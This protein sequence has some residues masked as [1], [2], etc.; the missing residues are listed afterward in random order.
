[1]ATVLPDEVSQT[2]IDNISR[3]GKNFKMRIFMHQDSVQFD[4]A[5]AGYTSGT[6]IY[7]FGRRVWVTNIDPL[8]FSARNGLKVEYEDENGNF[9]TALSTIFTVATVTPSVSLKVSIYTKKIRVTGF[10]EAD[11]TDDLFPISCKV[12]TEKKWDVTRNIN[13][14]VDINT[15]ASPIDANIVLPFISIGLLNEDGRWNKN[16]TDHFVKAYEDLVAGEIL[17]TSTTKGLT[18]LVKRGTRVSC[19]VMFLG[20]SF[21]EDDWILIGVFFARKWKTTSVSGEAAWNAKTPIKSPVLEGDSPEDII[22]RWISRDDEGTII[23]FN[24]SG[25]EEVITVDEEVIGEI[26]FEPVDALI[27]HN[28]K[29]VYASCVDNLYLFTAER[30]TQPINVGK[31]FG[32]QIYRS[33]HD[34]S[35]RE[36]IGFVEAICA[37]FQSNPTISDGQ[38]NFTFQQ[39]VDSGAAGPATAP[40]GF[41]SNDGTTSKYVRDIHLVADDEYLWITYLGMAQAHFQW[42]GSNTEDVYYW[43]QESAIFRLSKDGSGWGNYFGAQRF[44]APVAVPQSVRTVQLEWRF[45]PYR[46]FSDGYLQVNKDFLDDSSPFTP[47]IW[48][49]ITLFDDNGT[50]K[51]LVIRQRQ[52]ETTNVNQHYWKQPKEITLATLG[53]KI[54]DVAASFHIHAIM[55]RADISYPIMFRDVSGAVF[56]A[57]SIDKDGSGDFFINT[58]GQATVASRFKSMSYIGGSI[59]RSSDGYL[60]ATEHVDADGVVE[61]YQSLFQLDGYNIIHYEHATRNNFLTYRAPILAIGG[62]DLAKDIIEYNREFVSGDTFAT[63]AFILDLKTGEITLRQFYT[64]SEGETLNISYDFI[65][66]FL[67]FISEAKSRL[68]TDALGGISQALLDFY[69][70]NDIGQI[71]HLKFLQKQELP[72]RHTISEYSKE[73]DDDGEGFTVFGVGT[74]VVD[75]LNAIEFTPDF[76]GVVDEIILPLRLE[77]IG[78]DLMNPWVA[79]DIDIFITEAFSGYASTD[80]ETPNSI[81]NQANTLSLLTGGKLF[82]DKETVD[83]GGTDFSPYVW[84]SW[85]VSA[86]NR[87]V[88]AGST[89][90]IIFRVSNSGDNF[91]YHTLAKKV[92]CLKGQAVRD[93]IQPAEDV[94]T[95]T[96]SWT[97]TDF[98]NFGQ[99]PLVIV[100]VKTTKRELKSVDI[101]D[102]LN[103]IISSGF[104]SILGGSDSTI[105]VKD[106]ELVNEFV[107]TTDYNITYVG[108]KF[109]I[110]FLTFDVD[111]IIVVQWFDSL[112][113]PI[114][115]TDQKAQ[116]LQESS[117]F[118]DDTQ[119]LRA[120]VVGEKLRPAQV[121]VRIENRFELHPGI[122][123]AIEASTNHLR[124]G[125][126]ASAVKEWNEKTKQ[127]ESEDDTDVNVKFSLE[128]NDPFVTGTTGYIIE[129]GKGLSTDHVDA[130]NFTPSDSQPVPQFY[131]FILTDF[132]GTSFPDNLYHIMLKR[133]QYRS[134]RL[135]TV[136]DFADMSGNTLNADDDVATNP[137]DAADIKT[138]AHFHLKYMNEYYG[139]KTVDWIA[140]ESQERKYYIN[141]EG[142]VIQDN[143]FGSSSPNNPINTV[144]ASK[145]ININ[146]SPVDLIGVPLFEYH[147][148]GGDG[149]NDLYSTD[150]KKYM[151]TRLDRVDIL[152]RGINIKF[153][154]WDNR[155][156]FL[157]VTIVG[158]PINLRTKISREIKLPGTDHADAKA[159]EITNILIQS[160]NVADKKARQIIDF[161]GN[162]DRINLRSSA[163]YTP[164]MRVGR[165]VAITSDPQNLTENL[166]FVVAANHSLSLQDGFRTELP[167]LLQI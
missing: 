124:E 24:K 144:F 15:A 139:E 49:P 109:I 5:G 3:F 67:F 26:R 69:H 101:V 113:D 115:I 134:W 79:V 167:K 48:G 82:I 58:F 81:P 25:S 117:E 9:I 78:T 145:S 17:N 159:I 39:Y 54:N 19:E 29:N 64:A 80:C 91:N 1:M 104:S 75:E 142:I 46:K 23:P 63:S 35:N 7:D 151:S 28:G 74:V 43:Q 150:I 116:I 162:S 61:F 128:F 59:Y 11:D 68:G 114:R 30:F 31:S 4:A 16:R 122:N 135:A 40:S 100:N 36:L 94:T 87:S 14:N 129:Y 131:K 153:S 22:E 98:S 137:I 89:Y 132:G 34:G 157:D 2:T 18:L 99:V 96:E 126:S 37:Q 77:K 53:A 110:E 119:V 47:L 86:S 32:F 71:D 154:N 143:S 90:A 163:I 146:L 165:I 133:N 103:P 105:A 95:F 121:S 8:I 164:R 83:V 13:S 51:L 130:N 152:P 97:L 33:S 138:A 147:N 156:K 127:F 60:Y 44:H 141:K 160:D 52:R 20:Q 27:I 140:Y 155:K 118:G 57:G 148:E 161:Y 93:L 45:E 62:A 12:D 111:D 66:S 125:E 70:V 106:K 73:T 76:D 158:F 6:G 92:D 107:K 65:N 149:D 10:T 38:Q 21:E 120:L 55:D 112:F 56:R 50:E 136:D 41:N 108:G 72:I 166:F 88:V 102:S 123:Q 84:R 42:V 85:D